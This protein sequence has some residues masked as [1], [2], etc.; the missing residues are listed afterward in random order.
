MN[1]T[2]VL[3]AVAYDP[4]VVTIWEGFRQYLNEREIDFDYVLFSNYERQVEAL[5]E[6]GIHVAWN[7]P[8]AWIRARRLAEDRQVRVS[9]FCMRDTDRDNRS[10]IVVKAGSGIES[11][12][13]L[14]RTTVAVGASDSPQATLLPLDLLR[15]HGL[16]A[17]RDFGVQR[18][19]IL[20]GLHG[21]HVGGERDAA[22]SLADGRADAACMHEWNYR[23]FIGSGLF[24]PLA[25]TVLAR[26][27]PYDHCNMTAGPAASE[28]QVTALR[29]ALLAMDPTDPEVKRLFDLEGLARWLE[30]RTDSYAALESAVDA[31]GFYDRRGVVL[32]PAERGLM[33]TGDCVVV[34]ARRPIPGAVKTRLAA[35]VGAD[36]ASRLYEA[37]L[38]DT[39]AACGAAG[40]AVIISYANDGGDS[41][42]YFA[43]LAPEAMLEAQPDASFGERLA[44]AMAGAFSRG[45][46][47][48]AVVGSDIPQIRPAVIIAA[49]DALTTAD[50]AI[51]PTNDGGYYILATAM[52]RPELFENIDW[53]SGRE[54][55]QALERAAGRNLRVT[56]VEA[57]FDIDTFDDLRRLAS[58]I[59]RHGA[60][61]CPATAG[62]LAAIAPLTVTA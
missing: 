16:E 3:G 59:E 29:D 39:L 55:A 42:E 44:S 5:L 34:M 20:G 28:G 32:Q 30:A 31:L 38:T 21:D 25:T 58:L 56:T 11:I 2:I 43:R 8:L 19:E 52:F 36:A 22:Q 50:V 61:L 1:E 48:V 47:R 7:S 24:A 15:Q 14:R 45:Y 6:G 26:T 37:F 23:A 12:D 51:G 57:A 35:A 60:E 17:D 13:D 49:L 62:A 54:F 46:A 4:K 40:V 10:V 53:S 18:H 41:A 9:A 27:E 33:P